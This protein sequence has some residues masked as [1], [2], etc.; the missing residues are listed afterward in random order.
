MRPS[1]IVANNPGPFTLSGTRTFFVGSRRLAVIDPGP[2]GDREHVEALAERM[3]HADE[4]TILLSHGHADHSGAVEALVARTGALVRGVGHDAAVPLSDGDVVETDQ[5][6]LISV[7]TPGH[8]KPHLVFHWPEAKAAFV[9]D[10]VLGSGDTTW[11]G[12]YEG[13]VADYFESL[14]RV[15]RLGCRVLYP[16]HGSAIEDVAD[17]LDR[18][19]SHRLVRVEQVRDVLTAEPNA[20]LDHVYSVVY[21][22]TVPDGFKRAAEMSLEALLDYVRHPL[23]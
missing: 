4:S 7:D 1:W 22:D 20:D 10:L 13:C 3:G 14:E 19:R 18:Y 21:G 16:A 8:A 15:G 9:A 11:V 17:C 23:A 6:P 12:E 2:D 5:G